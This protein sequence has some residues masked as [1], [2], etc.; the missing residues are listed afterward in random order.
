MSRKEAHGVIDWL[1]YLN[2]VIRNKRDEYG[3]IRTPQ[4]STIDE[5]NVHVLRYAEFL[6]K[7][8]S[9]RI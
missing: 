8:L 7:T 6:R 9:M 2:S 4:N 5:H 3:S 1:I